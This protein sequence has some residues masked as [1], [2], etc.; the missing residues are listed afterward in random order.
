MKNLKKW[1]TSPVATVL[2]FVAAAGLLL[3][4]TIGGARAAF[5][6]ISETYT[7]QVEMFDI[8]VTL[9]EKSPHSPNN[10]AQRVAYRNYVKNSQDE[11]TETPG[12][13]G[14]LLDYL[15][16][17]DKQGNIT[18]AFVP[19]KTY[20]EE[21]SVRNTGTINEWVRV[22]IYKYWTRDPNH[23]RQLAKSDDVPVI[24]PELSPDLI[25]LGYTNVDTGDGKGDWILDKEASSQTEE[26]TVYYY[27]KLL[28]SGKDTSI[29]T[30]TLKVDDY[31][32]SKVSQRTVEEDGYKKIITS[33]DYDG[34][35]FCIEATVDAV[36]ER[37]AVDAI[38]SAWGRD[39]SF[40][41]DG[42]MVL[43]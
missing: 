6:A 24:T 14:L 36:Q 34:W 35:Q 17:K 7:G 1:I 9:M 40:R 4:S 38:K 19:G 21:I 3:F 26:R 5:L 37:N 13:V 42:T 12:G 22:T 28:E 23:A 11:W 15:L 18:E 41:D 16:P 2:L 33:Y 39:V 27:N 30:N 20:S 31:V 32:A 25:Q 29:L 8:G 43:E 10:E